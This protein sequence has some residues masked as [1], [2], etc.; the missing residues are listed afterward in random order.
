M[1]SFFKRFIPKGEFARN[2][3]TLMAGTGFAQAVPIL[4][5]PILTRLYSPEE[6][7]VFALY[8]SLVLGLLTLA[9]LRYDLAIV[10]PDDEEKSRKL[11]LLCQ[12][13]AIIFAAAVLATMF[14]LHR[15]IVKWFNNVSLSFW[16]Y[17]V[18]LNVL[19]MA[20][21]AIFQFYM[22]RHKE[23]KTMSRSKMLQSSVMGGSQILFGFVP[24]ITGVTGIVLGSILGQLSSATFLFRRARPM[25][26]GTTLSV[27][28]AKSLMSEYKKMPLLN[29][30]N[31]LVD[32]VRVNGINVLIANSFTSVLLGQFSLAWRV[33]Q[34]PLSLIN[35]ALSQVCFQ[36]MA[37]MEK[38]ELFNFIK[39][40]ILRSALIGIAP[41]SL[42]YLLSPTVFPIIFGEEWKN[43]GLVAR[44]LT[45]WLFLNLITSPISTFFIVVQRQGTLFIFACFYMAIPLYVI[46]A[47]SH[48]FNQAI[49][50]L[51]ISMSL[52]LCVFVVMVLWL[53]N[54]FRSQR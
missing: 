41:F 30:P 47:N 27:G 49:Q 24:Q 23:Y 43:A 33:L 5:S 32:S 9:S 39:R 21:I 15:H 36:Q 48:N 14:V 8:S 10:L 46:W 16:L 28:D 38:H 53:S 51:S 7:G 45:P 3:S 54:S 26:K 44:T 11:V 34:S 13:I 2:V 19:V 1:V 31:A 37:S 4:I 42:L 52:L 12:R 18:G 25:L 17:V 50:L 6:F 35:G 40:S 22:N 29:G 20:H